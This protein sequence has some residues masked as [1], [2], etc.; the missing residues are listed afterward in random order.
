MFTFPEKLL[1]IALKHAHLKCRVHMPTFALIGCPPSVLRSGPKTWT[2]YQPL[3]GILWSLHFVSQILKRQWLIC[4]KTTVTLCFLNYHSKVPER[5]PPNLDRRTI[6]PQVLG[7]DP[8]NTFV[9][10]FDHLFKVFEALC[11]LGLCVSLSFYL[12]GHRNTT[13]NTTTNTTIN[14]T[15]ITTDTT[16]TA[17]ITT[18]TINTTTATTNIPATQQLN[19]IKPESGTTA[20]KKI[21]KTIQ[22]IIMIV[23]QEIVMGKKEKMT[24]RRGKPKEN[25]IWNYLFQKKKGKETV[26]I[27]KNQDKSRM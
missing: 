24:E 2:P 1:Y 4:L 17:N 9:L 19:K 26:T 16:N 23:F 25:N 12:V 5:G 27:Q 8:T 7:G 11:F 18:N 22:Q 13:T 6:A 15:N 3:V 14:T 21:P 10:S 20:A